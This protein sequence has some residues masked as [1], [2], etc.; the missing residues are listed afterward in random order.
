[1]YATFESIKVKMMIM[2]IK[3]SVNKNNG[4]G[5]IW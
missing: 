4:L 1:M 3:K 2:K 5:N